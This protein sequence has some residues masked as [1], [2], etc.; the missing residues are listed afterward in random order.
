MH[1]GQCVPQTRLLAPA[2]PI[3]AATPARSIS[4]RVAVSNRPTI[5]PLS[6]AQLLHQVQTRRIRHHPPANSNSRS[7]GL[8]Q[9]ELRRIFCSAETPLMRETGETP[10]PSGPP[11]RRV[12]MTADAGF[13]CASRRP[14]RAGDANCRRCI[15]SQPTRRRRAR[16]V[17]SA[18]RRC[19]G[20]PLSETKV[21]ADLASRSSTRSARNSSPSSRKRTSCHRSAAN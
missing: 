1:R 3:L 21:K 12:G 20:A 14:Q 7:N 2:K 6:R 8:A 18:Q 13:V 19:N 9:S 17:W 11:G 15:Q 10:P 4:F 5:T 16:S